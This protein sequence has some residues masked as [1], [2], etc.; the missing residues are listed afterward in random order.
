ME[1]LHNELVKSH[2]LALAYKSLATIAIVCTQF[3]S[4]NFHVFLNLE[5]IQMLFYVCLV[6]NTV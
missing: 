3:L 6:F 1:K 5:T 4:I 2:Y